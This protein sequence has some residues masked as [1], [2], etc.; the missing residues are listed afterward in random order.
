MRKVSVFTS[1]VLGAAL[2]ASCGSEAPKSDNADATAQE[3]TET[4][5]PEKMTWSVDAANS[6]VEWKGTMVGV[7]DHF[8]TIKLTE[9]SLEMEG[10][11]VVGGS[12]TVDMTSIVPTDSNYSEEH[13]ADHLVGHLGNEDFFDVA[14]NPTAT[15]VVTGSDMA[16]GTITGDLT[17]RGKTNSETVTNVVFDEST[18]TATGKL[19]FNRQ[20]Y[21]AAYKAMQDMVLSD[22]IELTITL[23]AGEAAPAEASAH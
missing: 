17:V 22:D 16:A 9:G 1:V 12:F 18:S 5:A 13:P 23:K 15:F 20:T 11:N 21:G 6:M 4:K 8:G 2:M 14:N 19:V 7:Y 3:Q 10:N